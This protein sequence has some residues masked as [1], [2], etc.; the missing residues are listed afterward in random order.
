MALRT[1]SDGDNPEETSYKSQRIR[2]VSQDHFPDIHNKLEQGGRFSSEE[3]AIL[4]EQWQLMY[5]LSKLDFPND[6]A[7]RSK[8]GLP[9]LAEGTLVYGTDF[10][11]ETMQSIAKQGILS[12]RLLEMDGD[13]EGRPC[14]DFFRVPKN[15][16]VRDYMEWCGE[17]DNPSLSKT[18]QRMES[19]QLPH[20]ESP[21]LW[22][23]NGNA[24]AFFCNTQNAEMD[25]LLKTDISGQKREDVSKSETS[26]L[27][28]PLQERKGV[29][30]V[31]GG[32]PSNFISGIV[33]PDKVMRNGNLVDQ[34]Q[35]LFGDHVLIFDVL[36]A[37]LLP[38]LERLEQICST[39]EDTFVRY[40]YMQ[41]QLFHTASSA[42]LEI[43]QLLANEAR[44]KHAAAREICRYGDIT[45]AKS[46]VGG[47]L[48][49]MSDAQF[50][51]PRIRSIDRSSSD[52]QDRDEAKMLALTTL[53][54]SYA[55]MLQATSLE[56]CRL[57]A[58][59]IHWFDAFAV[60]CAVGT[61]GYQRY[62]E[63]KRGEICMWMH[64]EHI[65]PKDLSE[66]QVSF[67]K[68]IY[69]NN[70]SKY[71]TYEKF[72]QDAL[73]A[74]IQSEHGEFIFLEAR[75]PVGFVHV[76]QTDEKVLAMGALNIL[77][78]FQQMR[79]VDPF[80]VSLMREVLEK[81]SFD[82]VTFTVVE[83]SKAESLYKHHFHAVEVPGT[84]MIIEDHNHVIKRHQMRISRADI[85]KVAYWQE[86]TESA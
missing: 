74:E 37:Q 32:V 49:N 12:G 16:S 73:E 9:E 46:L 77:Q 68:R 63:K 6:I 13:G 65:S 18:K 59:E 75:H 22:R 30:S 79:L 20:K 29:V 40:G 17:L 84:Q 33:L 24:V 5:M 39:V 83:G 82:W 81:Y 23:Y 69:K 28:A 14:V 25:K 86:E 51:M 38:P 52:T 45:N 2:E 70:Y 56:E 67:M 80:I 61:N 8:L 48:F 35:E 78:P 31:L 27:D 42:I 76:Q 62:V 11:L 15:L 71:D 60:S 4:T 43:R 50:A 10:S 21:Y 3:E 47:I 64:L 54:K 7:L 36:G 72:L 34:V 44:D 55:Y 53:V 41:G 19:E 26:L 58:Q 66:E 1:S 85:E 57:R